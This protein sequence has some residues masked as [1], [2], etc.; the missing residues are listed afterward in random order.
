MNKFNRKSGSSP[1]QFV[2]LHVHDDYSLLD[3]FSKVEDYAKTASER[4]WKYL[5]VTNHGMMGQIPRQFNACKTYG[6]KPIYG[7]EIYVN[8][9]TK[10]KDFMTKDGA[11]LDLPE[12]LDMSIEELRQFIS[13]TYHL[14]LI[15]KNNV[16]FK[17]LIKIT[18]NAWIDGFYRKPR[19]TFKFIKENSDGLICGSACMVGPISRCIMDGQNERAYGAAKFLKSIFGDDFYIELMMLE[20]K[21]QQRINKELINV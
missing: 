6:L 11:K 19:A 2:H 10:Y 5:A 3:G 7:C 4:G 1:Q 18:S 14:V 9:F 21:E 16:G 12:E 13:T 20:M 8:D 17:N 15:A